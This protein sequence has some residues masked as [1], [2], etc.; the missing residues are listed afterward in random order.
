[1]PK[2]PKTVN[3]AHFR[4]WSGRKCAANKKRTPRGSVKVEY[5]P[6]DLHGILFGEFAAGDELAVLEDVDDLARVVA[7]HYGHIART[8][9]GELFI[10]AHADVD[11]LV[12]LVLILVE[13]GDNLVQHFF[14]LL[15]FDGLSITDRREIV[16]TFFAALQK[17]GND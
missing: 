4:L 10:V 1:M 13:G 7:N 14:N 6:Q 15:S 5:P 11:E 8:D 17:S 16:N 2:L 9:G 12:D 3:T